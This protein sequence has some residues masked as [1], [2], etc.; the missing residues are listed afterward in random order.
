MNSESWVGGWFPMKPCSDF[1]PLW[2]TITVGTAVTPCCSAMS[3]ARVSELRKGRHH[4]TGRS[5]MSTLAISTL[6]LACAP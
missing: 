4:R 2:N 5:S 3:C 6:P 1:L